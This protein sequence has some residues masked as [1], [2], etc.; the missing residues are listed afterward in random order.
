MAKLAAAFG[1][2][3]SVMLATELEDWLTKFREADKVLP[4][5]DRQGNKL[6]FDQVLAQAPANAADLVTPEAITQRFREM[7]DALEQMKNRLQAAKLDVLIVLGDDQH[8]LYHD[9]NMPALGIYYGESLRNAVKKEL[10]K[11]EWYKRGQQRRLE[12]FEEKHYPCHPKMA[13]HLLSGLRDREFDMAAMAKIKPEQHEGHAYSFVHRWYMKD[14]PPIPIVPIFMNTY[15]DPNQPL[16]SRCVKLGKALK[17]LIASYPEDIRVGL[18][19]SGGL[20]HFRVEEDIDRGVLD[21]IKRKDVEW[22]GSL[23]PQRL[24]AGSSE[25]RSWIAVGAAATDLDV[26]WTAYVPGYRTLALTGTGLGF[27]EWA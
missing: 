23:P 25:I 12:D 19:A 3:H 18:M 21:A 7:E 13:L 27:A 22:L 15:Y 1:S 11:E 14:A 24:K 8:E 16:P 4:F 9:E 20:S 6:T 26:K 2:S 17:E 5:Y 10:P